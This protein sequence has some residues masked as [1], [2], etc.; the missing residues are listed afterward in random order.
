M[1]KSVVVGGRVHAVWTLL[2]VSGY[3]ATICWGLTLSLATGYPIEA[4]VAI[5][6]LT[7][8]S[9]LAVGT[10]TARLRGERRQVLLTAMLIVLAVSA[11]TTWATRAPIAEGLD[12]TVTAFCILMIF[13]RIGCSI[14]GC[15]FGARI[16]YGPS[17]DSWIQ[18]PNRLLEILTWAFLLGLGS[19]LT[20]TGPP[21]AASRAVPSIYM[22][23][24]VALE[25]G[26]ADARPHWM[27]AS[28][29]QWTSFAMLPLVLF[30]PTD[31]NGLSVVVS[32]GTAVLAGVGVG[33]MAA[34]RGLWLGN[35]RA[36]PL[37]ELR[38]WATTNSGR[39]SGER[40][41]FFREGVFAQFVPAP[42]AGLSIQLQ[43]IP[44]ELCEPAKAACKGAIQDG[45][46]ESA[47]H[48]L[49]RR[50]VQVEREE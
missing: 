20:L 12:I 21:G 14:G 7:T 18:F 47:S 45:V 4:S 3:I 25:F 42:E 11:V 32:L 50:Q 28:Q 39:A 29:A 19:L 16:Y 9:Y 33:L 6:V 49:R 13:G 37:D 41:A 46:L 36:L 27:G 34:L 31:F 38:T 23:V 5:V 17:A 30:W 10:I 44:E 43:G 22:L 26:R 2:V 40:T 1:P 15:C 35:S 24:R 48:S 8:G